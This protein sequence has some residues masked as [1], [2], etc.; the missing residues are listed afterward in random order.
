M[1]YDCF[2]LT[3]SLLGNVC[4]A[5]ILVATFTIRLFRDADMANDS[6]LVSNTHL[7]SRYVVQIGNVNLYVEAR[8]CPTESWPHAGYDSV[9]TSIY[10]YLPGRAR[11]DVGET[12]RAHQ[13]RF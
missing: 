10:L 12:L 5:S 11:N 9:L 13:Y 7:R 8:I 2:F 6:V 3:A 1:S 4:E